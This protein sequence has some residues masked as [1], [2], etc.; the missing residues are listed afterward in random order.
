L[1]GW[2]HRAKFEV[3]TALKIQAEVFWLVP[4]CSVA[5]GYESYRIWKQQ[6]PPKHWIPIATAHSFTAQ[7]SSN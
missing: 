7:K 3:F 2:Y 6:D 4:P 1:V 5:V